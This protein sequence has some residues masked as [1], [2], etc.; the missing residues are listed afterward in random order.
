MDTAIN[1]VGDFDLDGRGMPYLISGFAEI[2]QR[3]R[4]CLQIKKGS[5][6]YDRELGSEL[7]L[8]SKTHDRLQSRAEMLIKEAAAGVTDAVLSEIEAAF[9]EKNRLKLSLSLSFAGQSG[10]LEVTV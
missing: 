7:Y 5:F 4:L 3:V 2:A 10:R 1:S 6:P 9:D 8:L